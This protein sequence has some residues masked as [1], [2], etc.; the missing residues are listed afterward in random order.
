MRLKILILFLAMLCPVYCLAAPTFKFTAKIVDSNGRP[1][2]GAAIKARFTGSNFKV[3]RGE[4]DKKGLFTAEGKTTT[5]CN[6]GVSKE[7][8]YMSGY[9][10]EPMLVKGEIAFGR[11][12]PWNPTIEVVMKEKRN[13][14]PMYIGTFGHVKIPAYN[15]PVG[16]DLEKGDWV[17]PYGDGSIKDFIFVFKVSDKDANP[18]D[19]HWRCS[20]E[21]TFSNEKDGIQEY[22]EPEDNQSK[23]IWPYKAPE[24]GYQSK[25]SG[26]RIKVNDG[27]IEKSY[28]EDRHY[29]FR[30]RTKVDNNGN[31][32]DA[33]Y[34]KIRSDMLLGLRTIRF[35]YYFNH[36]GTRN[37]EYDT[38]APLMINQ[39]PK[40]QKMSSRD[41]KHPMMSP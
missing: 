40:L 2:E 11:W 7:G 10:F 8:Y 1:I 13:P 17:A 9:S 20:F 23:Y 38:E 3:E 25:W 29:I 37:L 28:K 4:T 33:R 16:Y 27:P 36:T 24:T 35:A 30:V 6:F 34:G 21:L 22:Y 18:W 19:D 26:F 12:Q 5:F 14:I 39:N 15:K 32:I 41:L 31:I